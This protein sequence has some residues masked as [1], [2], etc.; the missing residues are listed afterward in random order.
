M[1]YAALNRDKEALCLSS[2]KDIQSKTPNSSAKKKILVSL[3]VKTN[4]PQSGA[5][6]SSMPS[7]RDVI[8]TFFTDKL[9]DL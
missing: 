8:S 5:D 1:T 6:I 2:F 4:H 9:M 3:F 7:T